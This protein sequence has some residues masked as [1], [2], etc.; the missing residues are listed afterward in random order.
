MCVPPPVRQH[1]AGVCAA[2]VWHGVRG[3]V[4]GCLAALMRTRFNM[5]MRARINVNALPH[6]E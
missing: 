3:G 2:C 6:Y 5:L 1:R 4:A